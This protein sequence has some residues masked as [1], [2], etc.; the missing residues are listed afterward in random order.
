MVELERPQTAT[1]APPQQLNVN[2]TVVPTQHG[3]WAKVARGAIKFHKQAPIHL[4]LVP[5]GHILLTDDMMAVRS[6]GEFKREL[7]RYEEAYE[8]Y[9]KTNNL[10]VRLNITPNLRRMQD[11]AA[12]CAKEAFHARLTAVFVTRQEAHEDDSDEGSVAPSATMDINDITQDE[13][14]DMYETATI[15][16]ATLLDL[17]THP[18]TASL[19]VVGPEV[20]VELDKGEIKIQS[21]F[22][23][24]HK[25]HPVKPPADPGT[26][27]Q[28][29]NRTG[30]SSTRH[31]HDN[32]KTNGGGNR[33]NNGGNRNNGGSRPR[34]NG[35]GSGG[36][37]GGAGKFRNNGGGAP[38]P[39][40]DY[41]G[42]SQ[43]PSD[44]GYGAL[45]APSPAPHPPSHGGFSRG[46]SN[47]G[48]TS[49]P[50]R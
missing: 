24:Y 41:G 47:F 6:F 20:C 34:S 33:N 10:S 26:K 40:Y 22:E 48:T 14:T 18:G 44:Q 8:K 23:K 15:Y 2:A 49:G 27:S 25:A 29:T 19:Q 37:G 35:G 45:S 5:V 43:A 17:I 32:T 7:A 38:T 46:A 36:G 21:I 9:V 12:A 13:W 39:Q 4:R 16:M 3:E 30:G 28:P 11:K 31:D 50:R 42:P 1:T